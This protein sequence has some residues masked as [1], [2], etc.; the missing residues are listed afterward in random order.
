MRIRNRCKPSSAQSCNRVAASLVSPAQ[1]T[2]LEGKSATL[3]AQAGGAQK[4]YWILKTDG[5]ETLVAVDRSQFTFDAGRVAGNKSATLQ[6][7]AIC[8]NEVKA[9][10]IPITI[11]ENIPEPV[12][13]LKAPA[14]WDGRTTTEVVPRIAN[15]PAMQAKGAGELQ[16]EWSVSPIAVIKEVAPGKLILTR[17]QNSGKLTV[18]A[19]ISNGGKPVTQSTTLAVTEPKSDAW[20]ARTPA[21]DEKPEDGQFYSRDDKNEGTLY[22]NGTL[23]EA[24]DSVFLKLYADDKLIKTESAKPGVD[25]SYALA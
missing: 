21:K 20:V 10:E 12:F 1:V 16:M 25:K 9:R 3:A 4:V 8:A 11:Q 18:T 5:R 6:F 7:R 15:L 19:T 17:A 13:T 23:A 14:R 24:A 2:V 22:Y